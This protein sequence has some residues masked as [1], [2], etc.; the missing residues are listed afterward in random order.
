MSTWKIDDAHSEI[1]FKVKHLMVSTVKGHFTKFSGSIKAD[2]DNMTNA[3]ATFE[4]DVASITT[5]NA[6]RDG[7]LQTGDFFEADKFPKITF[8]STSFT[9]KSDNEFLVVGNFSMRGVTKEIG[10]NATLNGIVKDSYGN[11]VASFD[12]SGV[13]NR[14]DYGVSWNAALEA[15]GFAVSNEVWLNMNVELKEEVN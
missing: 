7:H 1:G 11:R 10:L 4:A 15:G 6:G 12:V 2:D 5:N 8:T 13:I 3:V 9:K 14:L